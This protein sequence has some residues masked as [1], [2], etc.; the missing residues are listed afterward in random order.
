[1]L[2]L[3]GV[4]LL[5]LRLAA[6]QP[7]LPPTQAYIRVVQDHH[8]V[9]WFQDGVGQQFFSLGVNCIGGCYGHAEA[10]PMLP[11][12]RQWIVALL[13]AWGFNTAGCWSS[14]SV[15]PDFYVAEQLYAPF[16]PHAHDVFDAAF[17]QGPYADHLREEVKPFRGKTNVMG[18]FLDNEPV[19]NAQR[20]FAF[21]L[22]LGKRTPGSRAFLAYLK[23]YYR[24]Q[25]RT[26]NRDWG[27]SYRRFAQLPGTRLP[28]R[29]AARL[30]QG[31]MQAWRLKVM[32]TYYQRYA[33]MIRALD[34]EHLILGIR[35]KGVPELAVFTAL[36]PFFDVNSINDY[37]RSGHLKPVYTTLYQATGKPLMITEFSFSG[38]PSPGQ[39]SG[40]FVAVDSQ[41][42]RGRGYHTYVE[43]AA[44]APFMVGMHWFMWS[45]YAQAAS[46]GGY[47]YPPDVNVGLVTADEATV[48]EDLGRWI[49][50]TNAAVEAIHRLSREGFLPESA[51]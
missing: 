29:D 41:G 6:A 43:Q 51:P 28:Q 5:S 34:P 15:W 30:Q 7:S 36:S 17:W 3:V 38:F 32:T 31:M 35:Y 33:A 20:M 1:M 24:G 26:L 50:R 48:Y 11:A 47:P 37:N 13:R 45:D 8:G 21:Y 2:L 39:P 40:L 44:R 19:W 10:T 16:L 4:L 46:T 25:I 49:T 14:P 9:W 23:T 42:N 22:R 27:T 18:Y 12:R